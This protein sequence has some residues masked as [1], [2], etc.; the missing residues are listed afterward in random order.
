[1]S[2]F[3]FYAATGVVLFTLGLFRL[4]TATHLLRNVI[5]LNVMGAGIFLFL[6][7]IAYRNGPERPDPVPHAMVLTGIVVAVSVTAFALALVRRLHRETGRTSLAGEHDDPGP[8]LH[9]GAEAR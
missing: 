6:V 8:D 4:V 2:A 7:A 5:A 1:V 3:T 9:A